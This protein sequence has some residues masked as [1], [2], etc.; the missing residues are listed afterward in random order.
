MIA[1]KIDKICLNFMTLYI[2]EYLKKLSDQEQIIGDTS[3]K[4]Q[5]DSCIKEMYSCGHSCKNA[6]VTSNTIG[7]MISVCLVSYLVFRYINKPVNGG[8]QEIITFANDYDIFKMFI[9]LLL[10]TNIKTLSNSLIANI[11]LP[12]VKPVLPLLTCNL[13]IKFGL[14]SINM[15][16]FIS[17]ILV[18]GINLYIIYFLFSVVY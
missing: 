13:R 10:L 8:L 3:G 16:E 12:I 6:S 17:D 2:M 4:K 18:F 1:N 15:G 11:I 9:G 5:H 14:F 7:M